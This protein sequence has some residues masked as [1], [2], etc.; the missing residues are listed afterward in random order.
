[1]TSPGFDS[2]NYILAKSEVVRGKFQSQ[3]LL[4]GTAQAI[5][6]PLQQDQGL[7]FSCTDYSTGQ[8]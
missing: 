4:Y 2:I 3:T 1:M 7:I 6:R 5:A 8:K